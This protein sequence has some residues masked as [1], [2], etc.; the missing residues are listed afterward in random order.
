MRWLRLSKC[1]HPVAIYRSRNTSQG[2]TLQIVRVIQRCDKRLSDTFY[3]LHCV[4]STFPGFCSSRVSKAV[5][6]RISQSAV[7][8]SVG[9]EHDRPAD[10]V[11]LPPNLCPAGNRV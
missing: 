10:R 3:S 9:V 2:F 7:A 6:Q 11:S 5:T 1:G 8:E 4:L